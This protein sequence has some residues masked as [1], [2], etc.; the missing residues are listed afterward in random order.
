[1]VTLLEF[2]RELPCAGR[3]AF[4]HPL[5]EFASRTHSPGLVIV[6]SDLLGAEDAGLGLDAL[7]H[8]GHDVMVLQ[9]LAEEEIEPPLDGALRLVDAEDGSTLEVTVDAALRRA[10]QARLGRRLDAFEQYCRKG[11][12]EYLRSSTAVP[13]EDVVLK[14]LRHGR[15]LR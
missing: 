11:G 2:L 14:Y 13:F 4:V 15:F 8:R 1:M 3:T 12:I 7:R 10:Y 6:I 5:R 9:I